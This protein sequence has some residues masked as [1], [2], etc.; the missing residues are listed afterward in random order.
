METYRVILERTLDRNVM[1]FGTGEQRICITERKEVAKFVAH[2]SPSN[3][4]DNGRAQAS[5]SGCQS[6][7]VII[8]MY[9]RV[10]W[11]SR[12]HLLVSGVGGQ[13]EA[14]RTA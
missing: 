12:P 9:I 7:V 2:A 1:Y 11:Q 13:M 14:S 8:G 10:A 6:S 5:Q 4:G 3:P